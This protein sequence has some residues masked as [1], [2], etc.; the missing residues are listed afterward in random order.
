MNNNSREDKS[1]K[2]DKTIRLNK[3]KMNKRGI[4]CLKEKTILLNFKGPSLSAG[5]YPSIKN[6]A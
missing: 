6:R 1:K 2:N 4:R 3:P 5:P